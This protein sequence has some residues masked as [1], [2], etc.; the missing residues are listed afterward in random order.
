MMRIV[1]VRRRETADIVRK[2]GNTVKRRPTI[3]R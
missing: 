2:I 1:K 3:N